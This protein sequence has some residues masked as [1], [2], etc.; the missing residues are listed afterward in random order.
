[1]EHVSTKDIIIEELVELQKKEK[2]LV[3]TRFAPSPTG[4][5]H[6]GNV[7][8]ALFNYLFAKHHE[9][10][11]VIRI[12]DT[13]KARS[14]PEYVTSIFDSLNILNLTWDEEI[15]YQSQR[16]ELYEK[17]YKI[18]LDKGLIYKCFCSEQK[19]SLMRKEQLSRGQPPRYHGV[20]L[21]LRDTEIQKKLSN[22]EPFCW[23]FMLPKDTIIEF[24][25]LIK[26]KHTFN[27]NDFGDFIVR[28]QDATAPF[29]FCN[30]IDDALQG[31]T[32]TLRGE[33]H[34]TNTPRQLLLL[35]ILGLKPPQYGHFPLI[36][37]MEGLKL[38]K[39]SGSLS[40][41]DLLKEG[42]LPEA[43]LN[44]L[45]R[46]G[47]N[48]DIKNKPDLNQV[49]SLDEL[50]IN[51]DVNHIS[52]NPA[53]HD[54]NHL[55]FWQKQAMLSI[56]EERLFKLLKE[57]KGFSD[58]FNNNQNKL[59]DFLSLIKTNIIMPQESITWAKAFFTD[60][61]Y[62]MDISPEAQDIVKKIS[63]N[64]LKALI[65]CMDNNKNFNQ[66]CDILE[67]TGITSKF[68]FLNLRVICTGFTYGAELRKIVD[69]VGSNRIK[70]RANQILQNITD[71]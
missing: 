25:D 3:K 23:R 41:H 49:L 22:N 17:F 71:V 6:F 7:R 18:L 58:I 8:T 26:G 33:D 14:K 70:N 27:S 11:F 63:A 52:L 38:S 42:Y 13:D 29:I 20:C 57:N 12:E 5:M 44:Y 39:R 69:L 34:L 4:I 19:L 35:Q 51:F 15:I 59:L 37:D 60:D 48:Y 50:A 30:A 16:T 9:G 1:M 66:V 61:F 24:N 47:H 53:K 36:N 40:I 68:V 65:F 54:H 56:S 2:P 67:K 45:A 46:L 43:V 32:H 21:K 64:F 31:I 55:H 62:E 10:K 28:R